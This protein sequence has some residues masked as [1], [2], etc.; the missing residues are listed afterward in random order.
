M[1]IE[2]RLQAIL[3]EGTPLYELIGRLADVAEEYF[4]DGADG[5]TSRR[6]KKIAEELREVSA[7]NDG[8]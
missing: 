7:N 5:L 2:Q 8:W 6:Y 1:T 3:D 4:E